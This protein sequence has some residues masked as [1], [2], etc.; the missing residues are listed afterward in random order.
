MITMP[1]G[2]NFFTIHWEWSKKYFIN[3]AFEIAVPVIATESV[4]A[5]SNMEESRHILDA[6]DS[7]KNKHFRCRGHLKETKIEILLTP[8]KWRVIVLP[9]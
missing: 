1:M 2:F 9:S 8:F 3:I 4:R 6:S 5:V 7:L